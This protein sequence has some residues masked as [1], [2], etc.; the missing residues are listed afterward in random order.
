MLV[1]GTIS[2]ILNEMINPV[3]FCALVPF[4]SVICVS[5]TSNWI[6]KNSLTG[7]WLMTPLSRSGLCEGLQAILKGTGLKEYIERKKEKTEKKIQEDYIMA[8]ICN[9]PCFL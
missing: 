6:A 2:K 4:P 7:I 8:P 5:E 1:T 9:W 3:L